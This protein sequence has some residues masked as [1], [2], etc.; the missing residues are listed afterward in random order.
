MCTPPTSR[1]LAQYAVTHLLKIA[2]VAG[3]PNSTG[4]DLR[5]T[6]G[7]WSDEGFRNLPQHTYDVRLSFLCTGTDEQTTLTLFQT[8]SLSPYFS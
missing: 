5:S 2:V 7:L 8:L 1:V 6:S 3:G 4:V